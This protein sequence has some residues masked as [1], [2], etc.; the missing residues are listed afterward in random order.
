MY[1]I[2][3]TITPNYQTNK[4]SQLEEDTT[5]FTITNKTTTFFPLSII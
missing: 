3:K 4:T 2:T 5:I 1:H